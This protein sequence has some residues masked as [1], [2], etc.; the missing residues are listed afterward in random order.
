MKRMRPINRRPSYHSVYGEITKWVL[1][2]P[3]FTVI[4]PPHVVM[5][6]E[7]KRSEAAGLVVPGCWAREACPGRDE[8]F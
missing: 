8:L 6:T 7:A 1:D 5:A 3:A 2:A 4:L